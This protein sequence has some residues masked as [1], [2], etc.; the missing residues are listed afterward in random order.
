VGLRRNDRLSAGR[1]WEFH[2][3]RLGESLGGWW[4]LGRGG[5]GTVGRWWVDSEST[6]R[7]TGDTSG[8]R[9]QTESA[10][11]R[12]TVQRPRYP[13]SFWVERTTKPRLHQ[14]AD[15]PKAQRRL[16]TK[17]QR[18]T[19]AA[20]FPQ[21]SRWAGSAKLPTSVPVKRRGPCQPVS[22]GIRRRNNWT[23]ISDAA[24]LE[25]FTM[26]ALG[27]QRRLNHDT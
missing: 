11:G 9:R 2:G 5:G 24:R 10:T 4:M 3:R 15:I 22:T 18:R 13:R 19:M 14:S 25:D 27:R 6:G 12:Y 1:H 8:Q 20:A 21:R 26:P 17:P 16:P 23:P 7:S